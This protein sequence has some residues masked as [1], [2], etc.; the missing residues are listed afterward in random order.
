MHVEICKRGVLTITRRCGFIIMVCNKENAN[1][2][3][4]SS[5]SCHTYSRL[6]S[7]AQAD[8]SP[9]SRENNILLLRLKQPLDQLHAVV[10]EDLLSPCVFPR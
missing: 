10:T 2:P 5:G 9:Q 7:S 4:V 6:M 3:A 8:Q 1:L